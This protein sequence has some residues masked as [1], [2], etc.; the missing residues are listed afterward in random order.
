MADAKLQLGA[1]PLSDATTENE[2]NEALQ[3]A[4]RQV[5]EF[6]YHFSLLEQEIDDGIGKL[7]GIGAGAV[8]IVTANMDFGR[9][10][11][12]LRSAEDFKA[13]MPDT[14]REKKLKDTFSDIMAL[15]DERKIVAHCSFSY[16]K[17]PG[18]V[19]F[20]RAVAAKELRVENIEWDDKKFKESFKKAERVRASVHQ[21]IEEMK[22][23]QPSLDFRDPRNSGYLALFTRIGVLGPFC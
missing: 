5:G 16:V 11:N 12:V 8:D 9:K 3:A 23:Y 18:T 19:V 15:N 14:E 13:A 1:A 20:R 21:L 4:F 6:L 10:V 17:Q 7:L 2:N 22:P